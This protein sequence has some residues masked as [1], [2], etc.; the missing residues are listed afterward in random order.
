MRQQ[1][2]L[3]R[4]VGSISSKTNQ[5]RRLTAGSEQSCDQSAGTWS[6]TAQDD[7]S[8]G[9]FS[10]S[11]GNEAPEGG[12]RVGLL[13]LALAGIEGLRRKVMRAKR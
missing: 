3:A 9:V 7:L 11:G 10:F 8:D 13:G 6:F 2:S 4:P 1:G 12:A 5:L